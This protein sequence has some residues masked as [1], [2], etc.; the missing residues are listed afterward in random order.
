M[1]EE[2]W[3]RP[4]SD[5]WM[6]DEPIWLRCYAA[7]KEV[8]DWMNVWGETDEM[9]EQWMDE[10][11][12]SWLPHS[13]QPFL[14][15]VLCVRRLS[16]A[17]DRYRVFAGKRGWIFVAVLSI[18]VRQETR[19]LS[20]CRLLVFRSGFRPWAPSLSMLLSSSS[21]SSSLCVS[22]SLVDGFSRMI[23]ILCWRRRSR[24]PPRREVPKMGCVVQLDPPGIHSVSLMLPC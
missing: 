9:T 4:P 21:S 13:S 18:R 7:K 20:V 22:V 8:M 16:R 17:R 3:M 2:E 24:K 14:R 12:W 15:C 6:M 5:S 23:R 10:K 19:I 1:C 11:W